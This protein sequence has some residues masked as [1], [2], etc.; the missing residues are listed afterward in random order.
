M[1]SWF[2]RRANVVNSAG[3]GGRLPAE[4][5]ELAYIQSDGN[6][7]ID[8]GYSGNSQTTTFELVFDTLSLDN[9]RTLLGSRRTTDTRFCWVVS[10]YN[11]VIQTGYGASYYNIPCACSIGDRIKVSTSISNNVITYTVN[12]ITT[13]ASN[14]HNYNVTS[15]STT[16]VLLFYSGVLDKAK[17]RLRSLKFMESGTIKQELVPAKRNADGVVGMYDLVSGSFLTNAGSGSFSYG[18]L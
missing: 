13:G 3:G 6:Q 8:T 2:I 18:E 7:Y 12:N 9:N 15:F 10:P 16:N 14:S 11:S 1:S 5:T 4:F 17:V